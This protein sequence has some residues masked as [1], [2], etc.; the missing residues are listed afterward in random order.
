MGLFGG[1]DVSVPKFK[2]YSGESGFG[3][4]DVDGSDVNVT[5]DP[6]YQAVVR[7]LMSDTG[8]ITP[9]LS[10]G[11]LN[12]GRQATQQGAGFLSS[13]NA[14]PFDIAEEQ[15]N[16][17]ESILGKGRDRQRIAQ[18]ENLLRTGRLGSTGGGISEEGLE[19]AFEDSRRKNLY[20]AFG[21]AQGVQAQNAQ[22]GQS[23]GAFGLGT[24]Q[25]QLQ[26]L[27]QSLGSAQATEALPL[28]LGQYLN[29]LSGQRS[30]HQ[31]GRAQIMA[32]NQGGGFSDMLGGAL[33]AG[34]SAYTGGLG[35]GLS[36]IAT[37]EFG[38]GGSIG[39]SVFADPSASL[40]AYFP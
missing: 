4:I 24:E 7:Q 31:L 22:I 39:Q 26:R 36:N 30:Q 12:L 23:L 38:S 28:Q 10:Q 29:Q 2:A 35:G 27:L 32:S 8:Q 9:S 34:L 14:D 20:E 19:S 33:S 13:L 3:D 37:G 5:L 16:R 6:K 1:G 21:Q 40:S 17:M 15:F 11:Q 18:R 25:T